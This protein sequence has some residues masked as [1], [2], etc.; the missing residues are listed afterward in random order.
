MCFTVG[1]TLACEVCGMDKGG[2]I[3]DSLEDDISRA[4]L[5]AL[6]GKVDFLQDNDGNVEK[7][8]FEG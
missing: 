8:V 4:L 1:E 7:I 6:I 2:K 5:S 3:E